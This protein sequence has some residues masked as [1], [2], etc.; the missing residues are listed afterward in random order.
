MLKKNITS[1]RKEIK[2]L[3]NAIKEQQEKIDDFE[4]RYNKSVN[5]IYEM[6]DLIDAKMAISMI[7]HDCT[8][9]MQT[10]KP[11]EYFNNKKIKKLFS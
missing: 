3:P 7:I 5:K 4:E 9:A 10:N 2:F 8:K 1:I 11:S 6:P